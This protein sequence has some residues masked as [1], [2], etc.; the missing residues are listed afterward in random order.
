MIYIDIYEFNYQSSSRIFEIDNDPNFYLMILVCTQDRQPLFALA[1]LP[2]LTEKYLKE[3]PEFKDIKDPKS[4]EVV[5]KLLL[6]AGLGILLVIKVGFC[7]PVNLG[8]N[9]YN[10]SFSTAPAPSQLQRDVRKDIND[11]KKEAQ[12]V[13]TKKK[14]EAQKK[15]QGKG[16]GRGRGRGRGKQNN[17]VIEEKEPGR[18]A[19]E[20]AATFAEEPFQALRRER[21]HAEAG[22]I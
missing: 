21:E 9:Y 11:Q 1:D 13:Q 16:K 10:I 6:Q 20:A 18:S 14:L 8:V 4:M 7:E 3:I 22:D 15:A 2:E 19:D 17:E 5:G 12:D